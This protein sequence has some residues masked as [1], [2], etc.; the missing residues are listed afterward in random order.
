M[1]HFALSIILYKHILYEHIN[2]SL[3]V[4]CFRP[5]WQRARFEAFFLAFC[6]RDRVRVI[7]I[8][9]LWDLF[10][11]PKNSVKSHLG[12]N[13]HHHLDPDRNKTTFNPSITA[14]VPTRQ[15]TKL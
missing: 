9:V 15:S 12:K 5:V 1:L 11:T 13:S 8:P 4:S 14:S 2:E 10:V 6:Y 7:C 3:Y